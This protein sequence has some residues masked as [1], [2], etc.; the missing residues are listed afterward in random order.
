MT[1]YNLKS[2]GKLDRHIIRRRNINNC[3]S[4]QVG[5]EKRQE[6]TLN[7]PPIVLLSV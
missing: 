3:C 2:K 5:R 7:N 4:G 6:E 1:K